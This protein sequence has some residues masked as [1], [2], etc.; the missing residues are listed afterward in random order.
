MTTIG[1]KESWVVIGGGGFVGN[2]I[3][4][5]LHR[6][7][8]DVLSVD[9]CFPRKTECETLVASITDEEAMIKCTVGRTVV[10]NSCAVIESNS[11][12]A[13]R[14]VNYEG[15]KTLLKA[16]RINGVRKFI[17]ISSAGV[18]F[19]GSRPLRNVNEDYPLAT[20]GRFIYNIFKAKADVLVTSSNDDS[21]LMT[22]S[23]RPT[24]IYG[25]NDS[26]ITRELYRLHQTKGSV[27][28]YFG[29]NS[30]LC[31]Y[32]YIDN[33]VHSVTLA[34]EKMGVQKGVS[35]N[36]FLITDGRPFFFWD[37]GR[38]FFRGLGLKGALSRHVPS[39]LIA[40]MVCLNL[41]FGPILSLLG[42]RLPSVTDTRV[43]LITKDRYFDI[44]RARAVLGYEPLVGTKEGLDH[45]INYWAK[46]EAVL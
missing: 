29:S 3:A 39:F 43:A 7:K 1:D 19:D 10:V 27:K 2:A 32:T 22:V 45:T 14:A 37:F 33:V 36:A 38:Y 28:S 13:I 26:G 42:I 25:P 31:D 44:S 46:S 40:I 12:E 41:Y 30:V 23:L 8:I 11:L 6:R 9:V 5:D 17:H 15:V 35:G 16:C 34:A 4:E 21:K 18:H 24:S 20:E